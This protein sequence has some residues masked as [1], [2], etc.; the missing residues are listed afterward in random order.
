MGGARK[1]ARA[2]RSSASSVNAPPATTS[3]WRSFPF[4]IFFPHAPAARA[5]DR[6]RFASRSPC[7]H[8]PSPWRPRRRRRPQARRPRVPLSPRPSQLPWP[9]PRR[10][11]PSLRHSVVPRQVAVT[12]ASAATNEGPSTC[13]LDGYPKLVFYGPSAGG[14]AGSGPA[15]PITSADGG[16]HRVQCRSHMARP[17]E[18]LVIFT[19]VPV[20]GG[21]CAT[22]AS[23]DVTPPGR[24]GAKP[25]PF[26]FSPCGGTVTVYAFGPNGTENP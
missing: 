25:V 14:G 19:D 7:V 13:L 17:R 8:R 15:L 16:L 22:V 10:C 12:T 20:N 9:V 4:R 26:L 11:Y 6:S 23:V 1:T 5:R 3:P 2:R 21:G 24:S 18:F